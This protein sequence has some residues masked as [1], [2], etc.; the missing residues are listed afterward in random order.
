MWHKQITRGILLVKGLGFYGFSTFQSDLNNRSLMKELRNVEVLSK[1]WNITSEPKSQILLRMR[2]KSSIHTESSFHHGHRKIDSP[3]NCSFKTKNTN[4]LGDPTNFLAHLCIK[5]PEELSESFACSFGWAK[6][7]RILSIGAALLA[8]TL[9]RAI[10]EYSQQS[11]QSRHWPFISKSSNIPRQEKMESWK[12]TFSKRN[13]RTGAFR[14]NGWTSC[15]EREQTWA[16]KTE[17]TK[18]TRRAR[19]PRRRALRIA[20]SSPETL[21]EELD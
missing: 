19:T 2:N 1:L 12:A 16:K 18:V 8:S 13:R 10:E 7:T 20:F 14:K 11:D 21:F 5:Y 6:L 17:T 9:T 15:Q 4:S 3:S